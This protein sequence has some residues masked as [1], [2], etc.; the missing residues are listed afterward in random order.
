MNGRKMTEGMTRKQ[1]VGYYW[2]YYKWF[3]ILAAFAVILSIFIGVTIYRQMNRDIV[4]NFTAVNGHGYALDRT[5]LFDRFLREY[6]YE[7]KAEVEVDELTVELDGSNPVSS[8]TLQLLAAQFLS[9]D[10]DVF[11]SDAELYEKESERSA[12]LDLR[13][14]LTEDMLERIS[15][16]LWYGTDP[17]TGEEVPYGILVADCAIVTEEDLIG[18][19]AEPVLG[20]ASQYGVEAADIVN[21]IEFVVL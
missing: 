5:D 13:E 19:S 1:K 15:D 3:Y 6:G 17:E 4:L 8:N 9:G 18:A 14:I 2:Y 11:L 7:E 21:F 20:V 12:F 10:I 16:K